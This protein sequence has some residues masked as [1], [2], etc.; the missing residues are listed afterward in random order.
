MEKI[1]RLKEEVKPYF[2]ADYHEREMKLTSWNCAGI[3]ISALDEVKRAVVTVGFKIDERNNS[4]SHWAAKSGGS[5]YFT[6]NIPVIGMNEFDKFAD[7]RNE[8]AEKFEEVVNE[9][10]N[11]K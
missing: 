10:L 8:I 4:I 3:T 1:Y 2:D 6:V 7:R 5:I 11:N 9:M